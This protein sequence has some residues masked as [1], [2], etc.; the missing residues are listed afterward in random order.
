[1]SSL[2]VGK[3]LGGAGVSTKVLH[4]SQNQSALTDDG[5]RHNKV[6]LVT[7]TRGSNFFANKGGQNE[8]IRPVTSRMWV[9]KGMGGL[10][11]S[12]KVPTW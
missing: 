10:G 3:G 2:W 12:N 8:Q 11:V 6:A 9:G 5:G 4:S 1:M 7:A